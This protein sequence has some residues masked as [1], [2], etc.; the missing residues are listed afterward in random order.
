VVHLHEISTIADQSSWKKYLPTEAEDD[1]LKRINFK[2]SIHGVEIIDI[3]VVFSP[4]SCRRRKGED[5]LTTS[6]E[7][8]LL[9]AVQGR[10][11]CPVLVLFLLFLV[12]HHSEPPPSIG[13]RLQFNQCIPVRKSASSNPGQRRHVGNNSC[14]DSGTRRQLSSSRDVCPARILL[15]LLQFAQ[16]VAREVLP[17]SLRKGA[18]MRGHSRRARST[19]WL[20]RLKTARLVGVAQN[21]QSVSRCCTDPQNG[22][23]V[24]EERI[25][26]EGLNLRV[27]FGAGLEQGMVR[28]KLVD[29]MVGGYV[30]GRR[31][32]RR[33]IAAEGGCRHAC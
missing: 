2:T 29:R 24:G 26:E 25:V 23:M 19:N 17:V 33:G 13:A 20:G 7:H 18:K 6:G 12:F 8:A 1:S 31:R 30:R 9:S 4:D 27:V 11:G 32:P 15:T 22:W 3:G 16:L 14:R 10:G 21:R 5:V 28:R